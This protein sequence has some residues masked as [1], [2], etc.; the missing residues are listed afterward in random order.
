[1]EIMKNTQFEATECNNAND[2]LEMSAALGCDAIMLDGRFFAIE[3]N[4]ATKL[5]QSGES[6]AFLCDDNNTIITIPVN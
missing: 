6:F 1:M 2:A 5:A 3:P 4:Q